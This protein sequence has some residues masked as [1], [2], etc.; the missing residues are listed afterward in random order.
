MSIAIQ[1]TR[2]MSLILESPPYTAVEPVTEDFHGIEVT[3]PYRWL[4]DQDSERTRR[5]IKEQTDYARSYLD[6]IPGREQVQKRIAELLAVETI[7]APFKVGNRY[8]FL[9][10]EARQDQSVIC[11]REGAGGRDQVL[12]DPATR[13]T[14]ARMVVRIV[15]VS[16][17]GKLLAYGVREG[18]EDYQAVEILDVEDLK[19]LPDG[20]PRG[21][22]GSLAFADDSK[23]YYYVHE[24]IDAQRRHYRAA[25]RH[26][27]GTEASQDREIFFAGESPYLRLG[28]R[29]SDDGRYIA[30]LVV[31][32]EA[33]TT[34][35]LYAQDVFSGDP[36][37]LIVAG[38]EDPFYPL[39]VGR[40]LIVLT[41]WQ[42]P[43][44]RLVAIDLDAPGQANWREVV[45]ESAL[46]IKDFAIRGGRIFVSYVE[47][48]ATRTDVYDLSGRKADAI[49]YPGPG[50][51]RLSHNPV[52]GDEMFYTFNSFTHP[53]TVYSCRI[54]TGGQTVW[55]RRK[56][57]FDRA[58]IEVRQ[59]WYPSKDG[60][61]VPMFLVGQQNLQPTGEVPTILTGYGGFGKSVTPQF[62][63]F[64]TFLVERGCLFAVANI[65]GGSELGETWRLNGK[66]RK[67][68]NAFDD[69]IAAA[70]WLIRAGYTT[71]EKLAIAGASNGGLLVG[72][73]LTQRPD[74]FRAV[75]C[76][77]PLLDMLG[78]HRFDFAKMWI[79][80]YGS[81]DDPE[82]FPYL[83]A[84]S[85]YH[86]V[87]DGVEYPAVL[88]VSGDADTRCNPLHARKMT[89]RLQAATASD[90]PILLE[91]RALR[92]HMPV[93]PLTERI[94]ALTDRL[95]FI[96]DQLGVAV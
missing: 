13:G 64:A 37:Q 18:G 70:E 42:A 90:R 65:R 67:R 77:G 24:V 81:S 35:D 3:D 84:Y 17:D 60:A 28:M 26:V 16:P 2:N 5:W 76:L 59:V 63:A 47:N 68:Q 62:S 96:C 48:I 22:L 54:E 50:T 83:Y 74:L 27:I 82:D 55:S 1:E 32:S 7:D 20:L 46:P 51:A 88:L 41:S 89:A 75:V 61:L 69:F 38:M 58:S 85:P 15:S 9:K 34:I 14:G 57:A 94:E 86:R 39:F 40:T 31:R 79:D 21:F 36:A 25:Y 12:V 30:H 6:A 8:F 66:R 11:M 56:A 45:P 87:Q 52:D 93:L 92:G 10:R 29:A 43:N 23:S 91:Y 33:K 19:V 49:S 73:A 71:P 80:E 72:A 53:D 44:K 78:Y 95:A 4:E